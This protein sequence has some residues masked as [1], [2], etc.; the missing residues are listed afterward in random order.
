[1]KG[2]QLRKE[3]YLQMRRYPKLPS[4][5]REEV[6]SE[7]GEESG[8]MEK[9]SLEGRCLPSGL[10]RKNSQGTGKRQMRVWPVGS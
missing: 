2:F 9:L 3:T 8:F 6:S 5:G 7:V 1:M 10:G 4:G